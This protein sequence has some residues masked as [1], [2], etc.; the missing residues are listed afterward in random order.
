MNWADGLMGG[1][2]AVALAV[3]AAQLTAQTEGSILPLI[4]GSTRSAALGNAG[5]ALGGDAGAMFANPA[6]IATIR[7]LSIEGSYEPYLAGSSALVRGAGAARDRFSL[8]FGAQALDYGSEDVIVPDPLDGWPP[9]HGDGRSLPPLRSPRR[10]IA[11]LSPRL[12]GAGRDGQVRSP[13]VRFRSGGRM[14]G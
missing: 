5:A 13:A 2:A 4:P 14:G 3:I 10:H 6:G 12:R 7:H 11:R 8:G 1:R 9:R